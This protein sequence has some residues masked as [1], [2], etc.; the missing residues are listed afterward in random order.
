[1][2]YASQQI[3]SSGSDSI[4]R[5]TSKT[6]VFRK[7]SDSCFACCFSEY[8]VPIGKQLNNQL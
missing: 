1:M 8:G 4:K 5:K 3:S 6:T 2:T 7:Y